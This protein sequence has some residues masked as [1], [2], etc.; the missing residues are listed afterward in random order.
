MVTQMIAISSGRWSARL[1]FWSMKPAVLPETSARVA[2]GGA[3]SRI[4][5]TVSCDSSETAGPAS[6]K[7]A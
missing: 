6:A 4:A 2:A 3:R 5:F 7:L 1:C